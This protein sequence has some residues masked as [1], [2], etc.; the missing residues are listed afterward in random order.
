[1]YPKHSTVYY[2]PFAGFTVVRARVQTVHRDG[3]LTLKALFFL[4]DD[5]TADRGGYLGYL[6]R[7]VDPRALRA[8]P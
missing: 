1:M 4:T 6:Y 7:R 5:K 2:T 3:K 8:T